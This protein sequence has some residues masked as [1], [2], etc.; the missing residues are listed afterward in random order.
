[1][2][3]NITQYDLLISCPGDIQSEIKLIEQ[4]VEEFNERYSDTLG[5][6]IRTRHWRK[7]SYAQSGGKPQALL[8]EQFVK[9]CDAAVALLWTRF[10]TP[11]DEYGSGTEEE[12]EI[13][14]ETKKQVFMYFSDK[15][16]P[17][18]KHDPTEY[19]RVQAFRESYTKRGIY[20]TYASDEEFS[21]LFFAHLS[22]HFLSIKSVAELQ[23]ARAPKL[24]LRGINEDGGLCNTVPV[25]SFKLNSEH[26]VEDFITK[27][28]K[29]YQDVSGLHIG[30][31]IIKPDDTSLIGAVG[32]AFD[33]FYPAVEIE[34]D[35][36]ELLTQM[37]KHFEYELP[38]DFF[39]LG[40]LS[41]NIFQGASILGDGYALNGSENEKRKYNLIRN[42]YDT[43]VEYSK[44]IP[45]EDAFSGIHCIK[46]AIENNGTAIDED[47][48]VTITL[49]NQ[50]MLSLDEFP[51]LDT[52]TKKYLLNDCDMD[53]LFCIPGTAQYKD[54]H[55]ALKF[56]SVSYDRSSDISGIPFYSNE[57]DCNENYKDMLQD[58]FCYSVYSDG[59]NHILKLKFDYIKH[60]TV[61]AFPTA[62][63]LKESPEAIAYEITSRNSPDIISRSICVT[64]KEN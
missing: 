33:S 13:M 28:R 7:S 15:P 59:N 11:T 62:I 49:S 27:I 26:S 22:K 57:D 23:E 60:H 32:M 24:F 12:I 43:I 46:L 38:D 17:P 42:L 30:K 58:V 45:V 3:K 52:I 35:H 40:N 29:M 6:A 63:F 8:N 53:E 25:H 20:S 39:D 50:V 56:N 1:M 51:D 47:I 61:I 54:F 64:N 5:I 4:A 37:A 10:G 21:K 2:P 48:E 41:R 14:L 34:D 31:R 55:S 44:W 9:D 16:V 18:S 36:K 19:A